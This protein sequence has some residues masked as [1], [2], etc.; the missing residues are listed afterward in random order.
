MIHPYLLN[1]K[2]FF[3]VLD[4]WDE[5]VKLW[6]DDDATKDI[7]LHLD[8]PSGLERV[9]LI[10]YY[11][12]EK[13]V[14]EEKDKYDIRTNTLDFTATTVR[15][16]ILKVLQ[17]YKKKQYRRDINDYIFF[18]GFQTVATDVFGRLDEFVPE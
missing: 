5:C 6:K 9:L 17:F 3:C 4:T 8:E 10:R 16:A 14:D 12:V 2:L 18:T 13:D 1:D 7:L 15:G 11:D